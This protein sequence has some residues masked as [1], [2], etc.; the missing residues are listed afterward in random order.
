MEAAMWEHPATQGH[1]ATL[2]SRGVNILGPVHGRLASGRESTGRMV[3]ADEIVS[4]V[5]ERLGAGA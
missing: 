2:T 3:E 4:A 5:R 1:A